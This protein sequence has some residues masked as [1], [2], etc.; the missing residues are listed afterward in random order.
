MDSNVRSAYWGFA[1]AATQAGLVVGPA[2][3]STIT[4]VW[5]PAWV[6][7]VLDTAPMGSF[8]GEDWPSQ[9]AAYL[10]RLDAEACEAE[11]RLTGKVT[12]PELETLL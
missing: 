6:R 5:I 3:S 10:R 4:G 8:V 12:L 7:W 2:T 9:A 1:E 11:F